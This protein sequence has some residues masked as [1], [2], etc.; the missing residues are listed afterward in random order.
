M[1]LNSEEKLTLDEFQPR[2]YQ[3]ALFDAMF[4][5]DI[6]RII[7]CW[8]RRGGKDFAL[9]NAAVRW[10]LKKPCSVYY[11]GE[12]YGAIR[13]IIWENKTND[14]RPFLDYIP[15]NLIE[16]KNESRMR[17]TFKNGSILQ[18]VGADSHK[19]SFRGSNPTLVVLSEFAYYDDPTVIDTVSPILAANG[20]SLVLAST[21]QGK[22][23]Y[24]QLYKM[25]QELPDWWVSTKTVD[26]M[27][28]I[29]F[30]EL[31][32]ERK[33]M[34]HEKYL[35]EFYCDFNRG[36]D[37]AIFGKEI[38]RMRRDGRITSVSWEP[39]LL[40]H[41]AWDLGIS[42]G[43]ENCIIF[44]QVAGQGTIIRIIDCYSSAN[45]GLDAY[46]SILQEKGERYKYGIHLAPHDIEVRENSDGLSRWQKAQD[47]GIDFVTLKQTLLDDQIENTLT[48]IGKVWI[49]GT[50]CKSLL[51]ALE[52]YYREWDELR[53][54]YRPKPVHNWASNY[55][56]AF[57]AI[58]LG[59]QYCTTGKSPEEYDRIRNEALY[60][61]N[62]LPRIFEQGMRNSNDI[63]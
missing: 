31:E 37:G 6:K 47:L 24:F 19:T 12:T 5:R 18:F 30:E 22:N 52:N 40:V 9:F 26:D 60:G 48:H 39:G 51:D 59:M 32:K 36:V 1:K 13:Q 56:S 61:R 3:E 53:Q 14:G 58:F 35:Q 7:L 46:A 10:C 44:F 55:S 45:L 57:M 49:D 54:V 42:K 28:H 20:G 43:N 50:K 15:Q 62:K 2:D 23:A 38:Q 4:N 33:R 29:T 17:I 8:A 25:A 21:P 34:S 63:Y 16:K 41:T 27:H 11:A